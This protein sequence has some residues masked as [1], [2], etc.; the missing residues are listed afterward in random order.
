[1]TFITFINFI[2]LHNP[3][4]LHLLIFW[5]AI[6][7]IAWLFSSKA[8]KFSVAIAVVAEI[9]CEREIGLTISYN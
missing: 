2:E 8:I 5:S 4:S 1:L 9:A 7:K 6:K 3:S